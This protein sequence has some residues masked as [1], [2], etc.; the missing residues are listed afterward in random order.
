M[1]FRSERSPP[2]RRQSHRGPR[3]TS[4]SCGQSNNEIRMGE[5]GPGS[6]STQHL[7]CYLVP[8]V[9]LVNWTVWYSD[10]DCYYSVVCLCHHHYYYV[11]V[12]YLHQWRG[13]GR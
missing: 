7:G 5:R 2:T 9:T 11:H 13:E 1:S 4:E 6:L 3:I 12:G 8:S 10:G